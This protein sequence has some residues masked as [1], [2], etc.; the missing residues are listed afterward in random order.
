RVVSSRFGNEVEC[1]IRAAVAHQQ[2]RGLTG[3]PWTGNGELSP[4]LANFLR[5]LALTR[6][7]QDLGLQQQ[8]IA[9]PFLL[10]DLF[11]RAQ[12]RC[13]SFQEKDGDRKVQVRGG[14]L[15]RGAQKKL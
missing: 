4:L 11:Q 9:G 8:V 15:H 7:V 6:R 2:E 13:R 1:Q 10:R 12:R 3:N 5:Y 14:N